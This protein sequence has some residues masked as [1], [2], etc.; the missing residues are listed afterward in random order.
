MRWL[1]GRKLFQIR[2]SE[3]GASSVLTAIMLIALLGFVA[4]SVDVGRLYWE[5]AQLQNGADAAAL[6]IASI[7]G[8][9]EDDPH[10]SESYP[11]LGQ[12]VNQSANDNSSRPIADLKKDDNK[13]TVTTEAISGASGT[14]GISTLI[15]GML[16]SDYSNVDVN[17]IAEAS[18]GQV[19]GATTVLPL[20]FSF[21][22]VDSS[23]DSDGVLQFLLSHSDSS[24]KKCTGPSGSEI[25]GGFG[26]LDPD[27]T[28][29]VET[30]ISSPE[31]LGTPVM[32][33]TG[34]YP[35]ACDGLLSTWRTSLVNGEQ[36]IALFPVY[37]EVLR[38]PQ[39]S[40]DPKDILTGNNGGY[41]IYAYAAIDIRGWKFKADGSAANY[42]DQPGVASVIS[43]AGNPSLRGIVGQFIGYVFEDEV[44]EVG[45]GESPYGT[46]VVRLTR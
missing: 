26:W 1:V 27:G 5:K 43:G 24:G 44:G 29:S 23:P 13:I 38:D 37:G 25:P 45:G 30:E 6:A 22:E 21:C 17:A 8:K 32:S 16:N 40:V 4:I 3:H 11:F 14:E 10:C 9:D 42:T 7:C 28:C 15:A 39:E 34:G 12:L 18:W 20:A 2:N 36:V 19:I 31:T 33:D 41:F 35:D 46:G